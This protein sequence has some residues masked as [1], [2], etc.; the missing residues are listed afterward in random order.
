MR[1][2][3][4]GNAGEP[5]SPAL[6]AEHHPFGAD[7]FALSR[8]ELGGDFRLAFLQFLNL[9]LQRVDDLLLCL[10]LARTG[11]A[12][13]GFEAF[14][15]LAV[16]RRLRPRRK[17]FLTCRAAWRTN[18]RPRLRRDDFRRGFS[19]QHWRKIALHGEVRG[20]DFSCFGQIRLPVNAKDIR[21]AI[22]Q[23]GP[24]AVRAKR[25]D[26]DG[27]GLRDVREV[28]PQPLSLSGAHLAS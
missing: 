12:L 22:D 27:R 18:W 15:F 28:L 23:V 3:S 9:L 24:V 19:N 20:N 7:R 11:L 10:P 14:L 2:R 21:A 5:M 25:E 26:D 13:L 17:W 6:L 4:S 1:P 16:W 8:A